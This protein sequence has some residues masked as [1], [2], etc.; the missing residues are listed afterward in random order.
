MSRQI[1]ILDN[2]HGKETAGKRSPEGMLVPQD[3]PNG[4]ALYEFEF[5]RDVAERTMR[6][7]SESGLDFYEL[8]PEVEDISL[9]ERVERV[10]NLVTSNP[11]VDYFLISIH[12]NAGGGTGWEAFTSVGETESDK[13]AEIFYAH[14]ERVFPEFRMRKDES[15]GDPDKEAH[16][17]VLKNTICPAVL[18]EN[19]FMDKIEDLELIITDEGRQR[20]AQL[21]H[22][23]IK[24]YIES[25]V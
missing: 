4:T 9:R 20:V 5:N 16:F 24:E 2:G 21:H 1:V 19:F 7:L 12:A 18:T 6:L 3:D 14:A 10:N 25:K 23:A 8:V 15:D 17:Y 13:I 22:D 11:D